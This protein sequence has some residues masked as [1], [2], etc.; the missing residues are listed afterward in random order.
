VSEELI[1][2]A[3]AWLADDPDE[4]SRKEL[5]HFID[6][7][8]V[9]ELTKRFALP[10]T[11][12]TAGLRGPVMS[13]SAGMN[14]LTV[15]K[16]T[17]AVAAWLAHEGIDPAKGVVVGRDARHGSTEFNDEV[18]TTLIGLGVR[19][20]EMP[21]PAP[22][23]FVPYLVRR[24]EAAAG[25]MVTASHN[26]KQDN[27]Y[28]LYDWTG[29][30]IIPPHDKTVE[31]FMDAAGSLSP[32]D[33]SSS[34]HQ[35]VSVADVESYYTLM[36]S[37]FT[38]TSF[39]GPPITYSAFHGVGGHH[40]VKLF[41]KAGFQASVVQEQFSPDPEFPSLPFPNPEES[42]AM[43]ASIGHAERIG[44]R[45]ILANDPDA[46]RLGVAIRDDSQ[47][48]ILKG[49]EIGWLLGYQALQESTEGV[50]ATTIVSS[51]LLA[52][53]AT[54]AGVE[55][56]TT[57]TGFKWIGRAG[58][59]EELLFGYEEALGYA[60]DGHVGDKDGMS[61]A[62]ALAHLDQ[63][64]AAMGKSLAKLLD[65]IAGEFGLHVTDQLSIRF[66]GDDSQAQLEQKM[67]LLRSQPPT[68]VGG[69]LIGEVAD[70]AQG[71]R[72]LSST[73]GMW[74]G[75]GASGRI[76][77]RPSGTEPKL[78]VYIEIVGEVARTAA[79]ETISAIKTDMSV[80]FGA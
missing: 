23:P 64:M 77:V 66:S 65:E 58:G 69:L 40:M 71:F 28:K 11:F 1:N 30:Q 45:L 80:F 39:D 35:E 62:L 74:L 59:N 25:I 2:Q 9:V 49:D 51:T 7:G 48:R 34:Q 33:R 46:D 27:G 18:V 57:L 60:V 75:L 5:Q 52:K 55:C 20:L 8:N 4:V 24:L 38:V 50:V 47:W 13:G 67:D 79:A 36:A 37:R 12:G 44:S 61:A 31:A 53:M 63:S 32:G 29:S 10:L 17:Q 19:V 26:P 21:T 78:K 43:D 22:T 56:R 42:G 41:E 3:R 14:R 68:S 73:N 72:G 15:R 76:V 16:A 54:R 70:L 6:E